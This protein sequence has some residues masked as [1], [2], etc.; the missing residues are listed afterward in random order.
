MLNFLLRRY[1]KE[2]SLQFDIKEVVRPFVTRACKSS[3]EEIELDSLPASRNAN[4]LDEGYGDL[5]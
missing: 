2:M 1:Q 4:D 5:E 3:D